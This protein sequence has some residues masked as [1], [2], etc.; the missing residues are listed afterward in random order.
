MVKV[1]AKLDTIVVD[2]LEQ[3]VM[4]NKDIGKNYDKVTKGF[5]SLIEKGTFDKSKALKSLI[6]LVN[7]G[8]TKYQEDYG[9]PGDKWQKAFP[10]DVRKAVANSLID[11]FLMENNMETTAT[12]KSE[13][14][15]NLISKFGKFK[16]EDCE[17]A[18]KS[19]DYEG[20][21]LDFITKKL[22]SM[23]DM[24]DG[25]L[26]SSASVGKGATNR[27]HL[28]LV[29]KK[30]DSASEILNYSKE[31]LTYL[32]QM[33][34]DGRIKGSE[35]NNTVI[36]KCL[37]DKAFQEVSDTAHTMK[38]MKAKASE[39]FDF[40]SIACPMSD[41]D[42]ATACDEVDKTNMMSQA[43]DLGLTMI[44]ASEISEKTGGLISKFGK[45]KYD[46]TKKAIESGNHE[47]HEIEFLKKKLAG[48][49]RMKNGEM[50]GR[51]A[52]TTASETLED[53]SQDKVSDVI[54]EATS[55]AD[56]ESVKDLIPT[57]IK[58]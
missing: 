49:D 13:E 11:T 52:S 23:K 36:I 5:K 47:E 19:G 25:G 18:I 26:E 57:A 17:K 55:F 24:K 37:D 42:I 3:Y 27:K 7:D 41:E 34:K 4:N 20:T 15:G 44:I 56:E 16:I 39:E 14:T 38:S 48:M 58:F 8:A 10:M 6:G 50:A 31:F 29:N 54:P 33:Q 30:G 28:S 35:K 1:N 9:T 21:E 22:K 45:L 12:D 40:T 51:G 32:A 2:E 43:N 46:D 53:E